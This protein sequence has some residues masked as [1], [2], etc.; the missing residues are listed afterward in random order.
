LKDNLKKLTKL[1]GSVEFVKIGSLL[2]DGK[3]I[4]DKRII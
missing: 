1:S 3:V 2:D 4:D